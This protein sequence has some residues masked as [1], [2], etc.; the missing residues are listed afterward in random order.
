MTRTYSNPAGEIGH[1][2]EGRRLR[3]ALCSGIDS[4]RP[5]MIVEYRGEQAELVI[6]PV[7][8]MPGEIPLALMCYP[9]SAMSK[10]RGLRAVSRIDLT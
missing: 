4:S 5:R 2:V 9:T 6:E 8:F 3:C 7:L 10:Q 1:A